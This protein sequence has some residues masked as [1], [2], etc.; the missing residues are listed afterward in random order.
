VVA[1]LTCYTRQVPTTLKRTN[2]THTAPVRRAL[3]IATKRWPDESDSALFSHI[4][5]E[6]ADQQEN[7]MD[8]DIKTAARRR[9]AGSRTGAYPPD[10]LDNL[11][12]EW[13]E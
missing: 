2:V 1:H 6:W 4:A 9:L 7:V 10:Y 13:P 12:S 3:G 11:R 8:V 5:G